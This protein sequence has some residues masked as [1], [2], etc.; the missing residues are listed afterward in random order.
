MLLPRRS[1]GR[2]PLL[3]FSSPRGIR[4]LQKLACLSLVR[5]PG[6]RSR[7]ATPPLGCGAGADGIPAEIPSSPSGRRGPRTAAV[8]LGL[9]APPYAGS[10]RCDPTACWPGRRTGNGDGTRGGRSGGSGARAEGGRSTGS[11]QIKR[12]GDT[13]CLRARGAAEFRA[14]HG[15]LPAAPRERTHTH[16]LTHTL[17]RELPQHG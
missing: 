5:R 12:S 4:H 2:R 11:S 13:A 3:A 6:L 7:G 14:A 10:G 8:P 1:R 17:T 15:G 9:R 16:T